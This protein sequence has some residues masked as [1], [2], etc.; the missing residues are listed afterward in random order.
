MKRKKRQRIQ[1]YNTMKD[2]AR[3]CLIPSS[4]KAMYGIDPKLPII[5]A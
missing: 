4:H 5:P 2:G 3:Y 1:I